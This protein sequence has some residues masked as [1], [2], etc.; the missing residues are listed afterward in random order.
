MV[1]VG[2]T[3][4]GVSH[5]LWR[6]KKKGPEKKIKTASFWCDKPKQVQ[7]GHL[8]VLLYQELGQ[9]LEK[10]PQDCWLFKKHLDTVLNNLL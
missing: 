7:P 3:N 9:T 5:L 8:E 10:V 1:M 4:K 2:F 6:E